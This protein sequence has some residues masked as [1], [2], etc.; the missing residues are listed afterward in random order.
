MPIKFCETCKIEFTAQKQNTRFCSLK[1]FGKSIHNRELKVCPCGKEFEAKK[2]K[3]NVKYCSMECKYE[4]RT[5]PKGLSYIIVAENSAWFPKGHTPYNKDTKGLVKATSGSIRKGERRGK[6][7]EFKKGIIPWNTN[8]PEEESRL[9]KGNEVGYNALHCWVK[10]HLGKAIECIWCHKTTGRIDWANI[11]HEY[12]R[13]LNDWMML[14]HKC[15]INYD[16][17]TGWGIIK[18]RFGT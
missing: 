18:E 16:R 6:V 14:C 15:H 1:C 10:K 3:K 8:I 2:F 13:E 5:R 4:Y 9:W 12:K 17:E 11:S 7:T